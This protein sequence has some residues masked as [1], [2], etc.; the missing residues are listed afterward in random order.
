MAV[1]RDR[2]E[3]YRKT[4]REAGFDDERI[5]G[6]LEQ[7]WVW[8]NVFVG[9][10]DAEAESI[11]LPAFQAMVKSRAVMRDRI[12][13]ETGLRIEV[14]HSD[15]PSARA[16]VERGFICGSPETVTEAIGEIAELGIG[17]V[18]AT[19]RLGPLAH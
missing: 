12:Y 3:G 19:F 2:M 8:R 18:I 14:P 9:K 15:L 11:G 1:T 6:N 10:T 13:R 16:S 4:M 7:C 5:A 17:G